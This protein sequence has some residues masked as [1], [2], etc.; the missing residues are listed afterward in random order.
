VKGDDR[1]GYNILSTQ[2]MLGE[3]RHKLKKNLT[4][5]RQ[6]KR[7]TIQSNDPKS[8]KFNP[9]PY[10]LLFF[11][12]ISTCFSNYLLLSPERAATDLDG[13]IPKA[14]DD[15]VVIVLQA[16]HPLAGFT[17]AVDALQG[18]ATCPPVVLYPL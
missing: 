15:F 13:V 17:A 5:Y 14:T 7:S 16:V 11:L 12:I 6:H 4:Q 18:M 1:K 2:K 9:T 10:F 8:F 3:R